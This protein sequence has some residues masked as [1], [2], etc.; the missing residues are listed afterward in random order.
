MD[1]TEELFEENPEL[2]LE[3]FEKRLPQSKQE[4]DSLLKI[5]EKENFNKRRILDLNCGIGRHS[6][7]LAKRGIKVVGTD[8]SDNYIEIAKKKAKELNLDSNKVDFKVSDMRDIESTFEDAPLFDGVICLWTSFG[9]YDNSTNKEVLR[10]CLE[11]VRKGGF[12]VLDIMNRDW[13][14]QNFE[15]AG[16]RKNKKRIVLEERSFD[17]ET[18]RVYNT[19][20]YLQREKCNWK[21]KKEIKVNHRVWSLHELIQLFEGCGWNFVNSY[22]GLQQRQVQNNVALMNSRNLLTISERQ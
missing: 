18:S 2:F 17:L 1:W 10:Q 16:F 13:L 21:E 6:I 5:L 4:V 12:F 15:E 19:W 7:E 20:T 11:L 22:P 9:F 8:L 14:I 3:E